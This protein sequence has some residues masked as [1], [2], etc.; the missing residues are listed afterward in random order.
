MEAAKEQQEGATALLVIDM[1]N[2]L[3]E[4]AH[5]EREVL[6][7]IGGL[8]ER[9]RA[10][11]TPVIYLQHDHARYAPLMPGADGWQIHE[12]IAPRRQ[13]LVIRKR[14]SDSFYETPL[15]G[16]LRA[17][18]VRHLVVTGMATE[19]CVDATS[20]SALSHG[21]DVTLVGDAHTTTANGLLSAEQI[22]AHHNATLED[23]AHPDHA[24]VVKP[25]A[26]VAFAPA[27]GAEAV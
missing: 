27:A 17:R 12:A 4:I 24:I 23:L 5:Q 6:E 21:Y 7:R 25:A 15:D 9:A 18:G 22:I 8:L 20:R 13:E 16:Q 14:A 3:V 26:E 2:A 1:Q 19:H 11:G 10:A